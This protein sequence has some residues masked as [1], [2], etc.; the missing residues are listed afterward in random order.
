MYLVTCYERRLIFSN[1]SAAREY[2]LQ[3]LQRKVGNDNTPFTTV[4]KELSERLEA[5]ENEDDLDWDHFTLFF[6]RVKVY[7]TAEDAMSN[8]FGHF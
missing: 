6:Q 8:S 1:Y 4:M 2:L 3:L 5:A 7:D